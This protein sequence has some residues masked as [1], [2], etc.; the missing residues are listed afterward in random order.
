MR[1][2]CPEGHFD[3]IFCGGVFSRNEDEVGG[4]R[5]EDGSFSLTFVLDRVITRIPLRSGGEI[6]L[7]L[8]F[9]PLCFGICRR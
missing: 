9:P 3:G 6:M 7:Q 2:S 4:W 5:M 8:L 1:R